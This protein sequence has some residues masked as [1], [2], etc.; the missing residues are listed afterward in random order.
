MNIA[1]A[2]FLS[3]QVSWILDKATRIEHTLPDVVDQVEPHYYFIV[4]TLMDK[5]TTMIPPA[6]LAIAPIKA[7]LKAVRS[8]GN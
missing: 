1:N 7:A 8:H 2:S 6:R 3:G 4:R 5:Q